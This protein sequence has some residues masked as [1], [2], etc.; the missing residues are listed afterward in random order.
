MIRGNLAILL[1][2]FLSYT[3]DGNLGM[4]TLAFPFGSR[5]LFFGGGKAEG[6]EGFGARP[7]SK[8]AGSTPSVGR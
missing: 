4:T 2:A 1:I 5:I 7:L 3:T 8:D 6:V